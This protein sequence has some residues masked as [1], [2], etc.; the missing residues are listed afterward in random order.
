M[1]IKRQENLKIYFWGKVHFVVALLASDISNHSHSQNTPL[2]P[3]SNPLSCFPFILFL[4]PFFTC[5][6]GT[7][8]L[9]EPGTFF[10]QFCRVGKV[11]IS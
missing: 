5:W 2:S 10:F 9:K 8:H 11:M 4:F 3:A 6:L 7:L 1:G